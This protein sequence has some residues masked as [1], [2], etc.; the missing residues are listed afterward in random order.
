MVKER[1]PEKSA[2]TMEDARD[3]QG[4]Y[5]ASLLWVTKRRKN[6][7]KDCGSAIYEHNGRQKEYLQG[8][9]GSARCKS[10]EE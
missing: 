8:S 10:T 3:P 4:L 9:G 6:Q 7:C 1:K 5:G 2:I